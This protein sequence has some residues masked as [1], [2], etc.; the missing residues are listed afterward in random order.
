MQGIYKITCIPENRVYIG[1]SSNIPKR[2]QRHVRTLNDSS[3]HNYKLQL[4]WDCYGDESFTFEV[5]EETKEL[6]ARERYW[7]DKYFNGS[8]NIHNSSNNPMRDEAIKQK[9]LDKIYQKY[10]NMSGGFAKLDNDK[11]TDIITMINLGND[12][13]TIAKQFGCHMSTIRSI[14]MKES[15][16][17]LSHLILD[18]RTPKQ[19]NKDLVLGMHKRG[20]DRVSI[21]RDTKI[22]RSTVISWIEE[23]DK[24][25]G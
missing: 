25:I 21:W 7:L 24:S 11:V 4:D 19:R 2:W 18:A 9:R 17:H 12:N 10:G 15:W 5:I 14:R 1:S 3:H 22:P 13:P 8:Y 23:Y 20:I 16:K 6:T